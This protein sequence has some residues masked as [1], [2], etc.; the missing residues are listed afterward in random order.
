MK[1]VG[2]SHLVLCWKAWLGFSLIQCFSRVATRVWP[3]LLPL[4]SSFQLPYPVGSGREDLGFPP[5]GLQGS[6]EVEVLGSEKLLAPSQA[7]KRQAPIL[8]L[9]SQD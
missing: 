6:E 3:E 9:L 5:R 2:C 4:G 1:V 7:W 8:T